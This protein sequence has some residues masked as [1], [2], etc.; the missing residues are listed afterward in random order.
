MV[1]KRY[2]GWRLVTAAATLLVLA[3]GAQTTQAQTPQKITLRLDWTTLGYHS[4]FYYGVA[5][6]YYKD[7]GIDLQVL[8]GKGSSNAVTLAGNDADDFAFADASTAARL[9][10]QGLPVKTVM[11]IFQRATLSLFFPQGKGIATPTDLKGKR[12]ALCA[13]DGL[14]QYLPPYLKAIGLTI[15]DIKQ[16]TVDCAVKYTMVAQGQADAVASYGTA[17]K[18][19]LQAVGV[20]EVGKFD[21][22]DAGIFLPSHGIVTSTK[23]IKDSP[24]LVRRFVSAT[25]RAWQEGHANPDAAVAAV[26]AASPLLRGKEQLLKDTMIDS[27]QYLLTPGTTGK[28]FGWQSKEEWTKAVELLVEYTKMAPPASPDV[29][30]TNEF[31]GG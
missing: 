25:A 26:V 1:R 28:P 9:A 21:Y 20:S 31:I 14:A 24:D 8:D 4:P 10:S 11:G 30:F 27:F 22:A 29:F 2:T 16:V 12:I 15:T 18:P 7:A 23:K 5:K 19:L 6:G 17:G 3:A 13:G